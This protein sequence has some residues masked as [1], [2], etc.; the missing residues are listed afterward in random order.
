[1]L[2][3]YDFLESGNAYKERWRDARNTSLLV[4]GV[5]SRSEATPVSLIGSVMYVMHGPRQASFCVE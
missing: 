1:M 2:R 4:G 3:L 5:S